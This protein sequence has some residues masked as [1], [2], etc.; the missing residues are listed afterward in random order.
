MS[1][2]KRRTSVGWL[3]LLACAVLL[4][5]STHA[6]STY[7]Q[8]SPGS[9]KSS[10]SLEDG[11]GTTAGDPDMPTGDTPPPTGTGSTSSYDGNTNRSHTMRGGITEA[12]PSKRYGQWAHWKV[13]LKLLARS[14]Y[15]R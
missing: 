8:T 13:M 5:L 1:L 12:V 9:S 6:S 2:L 7:A 14:F 4:L 3:T 11:N 10:G 15:L